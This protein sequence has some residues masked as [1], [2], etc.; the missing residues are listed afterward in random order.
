MM[1]LVKHTEIFH[2]FEP[3]VIKPLTKIGFNFIEAINKK[4]K[5]LSI[6]KNRVFAG[7][8]NLKPINGVIFPRMLKIKS[9]KNILLKN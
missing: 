2:I 8:I 1:Y 3:H 7:Y 4:L 9:I 6:E 5:V